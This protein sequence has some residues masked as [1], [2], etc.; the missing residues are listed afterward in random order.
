LISEYGPLEQR[1]RKTITDVDELKTVLS[2]VRLQSWAIADDEMKEGTI[3]IAVPIFD[4]SGIV[5]AALAVG[6][7]KMRRS[8]DELKSDFLPVLQNAADKISSEIPEV[9]L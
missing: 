2:Q 7:H 1:T 8:I 9:A 4:Q 6:S 3:G 5:I